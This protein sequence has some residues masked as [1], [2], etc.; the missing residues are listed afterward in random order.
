MVLTAGNTANTY[1]WNNGSASNTLAASAPGQYTVIVSG[2]NGCMAYDTF[3]VIARAAPV[4]ALD[5]NIVLCNGQPRLI[6]AGGNYQRYLWNT[7]DTSESISIVTTGIFWVTVTDKYDC[8]AT[9]TTDVTR[10]ANPPVDFLPPDTVVCTYASLSIEAASGFDSYLW[11][12]GEITA[13]IL[14]S[15]PGVYSLAVTDSNGCIGKDTIVVKPGQCDEGFFVPNAFTPNGDG[16]NDL[17]KPISLYHFNLSRFH[18]AL[19]NRWGQRV[20]E[21]S[22]PSVGWDGR[23]GGIQQAAGV[24]VWILDYQYQGGPSATGK[25][26]V[27]LIR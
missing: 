17:L 18:F 24:Y 12:T 19:Y 4:V 10:R 14:I 5:K 9:D 22:N 20:F 27:I 13:S 11:S 1:Q 6:D 25:G 15:Q 26:T 21:S 7:G 3:N 8:S 2:V 23:V 16:R